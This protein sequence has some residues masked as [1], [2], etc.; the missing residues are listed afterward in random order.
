MIDNFS[1]TLSFEIQKK[2]KDALITNLLP[3]HMLTK[4]YQS[5]KMKLE[6]SDVIQNATILYA[7]IAGFT[8]YS[9]SVSPESVVNMLRI[10]MTEFD[11]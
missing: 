8:T 2:Q 4:F 6:L 7:D 3:S 10:L 9:A 11:K 1:M 5:N